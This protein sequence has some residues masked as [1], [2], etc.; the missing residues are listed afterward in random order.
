MSV[1]VDD[2]RHPFGR[3]LMCH[4]WA[5]SDAE[6][7]AMADRIGVQ[8]KWSQGHKTLSFGKH[9]NASW[10]HFDIVQAK[11]AL[12]VA[13]GAIETDRYG[14]V[15]HIARLKGD[16]ARLDTIAALRARAASTVSVVDY[17]PAKDAH[18]SYFAAIEAK[19]LRGDHLLGSQHGRSYESDGTSPRGTADCPRV[20][21]PIPAAV[22]A[23]PD[24]VARRMKKLG[25]A[26]E[27]EIERQ[28]A[29]RQTQGEVENGRP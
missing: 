8:R 19:R 11:R 27:A 23:R 15:E 16:Q 24:P 9:R 26:L 17:D 28:E 20:S 13:A 1:Y 2:A 5:D 25:A 21:A 29:L 18:D 4:M 10:V 14:P 3:Y 7:L 12:A 22:R 6:L